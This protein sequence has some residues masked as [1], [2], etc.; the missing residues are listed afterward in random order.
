MKR[1]IVKCKLLSKDSFCKKLS[2]IDL[3]FSGVHWQHD[4]IYVPREYKKNSSYPRL[5]MRTDVRGID[6]PAVYSLLLKRH[7]EDS[8]TDI[9]EETIVQDY[10]KIVSIILQLGFKPYAEVS[11]RRQYLNMGEG[12]FIYLDSI[13]NLPGHY[14]KIEANLGPD[15]SAREAREDLEGTFRALGETNF[16]SSPYFEM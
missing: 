3:F 1:V 10:G 7:I 13:D 6:K 12:V 14:A 2:D 8:G 15:D 11:R 4:R 9:V 16:I 5:I